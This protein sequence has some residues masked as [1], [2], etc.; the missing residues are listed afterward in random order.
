MAADDCDET[1][2]LWDALHVAL[3]DLSDDESH[4][5]GLLHWLHAQDTLKSG[6]TT[7]I[8]CPACGQ[9]FLVQRDELLQCS[10][11]FA[12]RLTPECSSPQQLKT[13][14]EQAVDE[15]HANGCIRAPMF[16]NNTDVGCDAVLFA[17]C[18]ACAF[19]AVV[20]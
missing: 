16:G 6:T 5:H 7:D 4:M 18:D 17:T 1:A 12:L 19:C 20:L 10:C 8:L 11:S 13:R 14:L 15:H 2:A 3:D 9:Q